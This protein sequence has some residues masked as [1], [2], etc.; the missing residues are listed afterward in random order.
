MAY[1]F[2]YITLT[3]TL[4]LLLTACR[5]NDDVL[6]DPSTG[7]G[8][9]FGKTPIELSVGGVDTPSSALTR[10]VITDGTGERML[11]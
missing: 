7:S 2:N 9:D 1:K 3:L 11:A 6:V 4:C 10:A 5:D 8:S